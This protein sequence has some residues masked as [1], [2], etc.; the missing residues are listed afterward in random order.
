[1]GTG[2][3]KDLEVARN[4]LK[5]AEKLATEI[6][7]ANS[8]GG[9]LSSVWKS[10]WDGDAA[11][12][13]ITPEQRRRMWDYFASL[14]CQAEINLNL[15]SLCFKERQWMS[16]GLTARRSWKL[17]EEADQTWKKIKKYGEHVLPE[18]DRLEEVDILSRLE[19][20]IGLYHFFVSLVPPGL[21]VIVEAIGFQANRQLGISEL[22]SA[23]SRKG[24]H[25]VTA[26]LLLV[27][28]HNFF[29]QEDDPAN[30]LISALVDE[31]YHTSPAIRLMGGTVAR[32][33]G[34]IAR[35]IESYQLVTI[36]FS[37][38]ENFFPVFFFFFNSK[39]FFLLLSLSEISDINI[40][41]DPRCEKPTPGRFDP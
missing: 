11:P 6:Q 27:A 31:G 26:S 32:R 36:F 7:E 4:A 40:I 16:I 29:M 9:T 19:F 17:F 30:S 34:N 28:Y 8:E 25:Y 37:I 14:V 21:L 15:L 39:F 10:L 13:E 35:A 2:T 33:Q 5:D 18:A 1:M 23:V 41:G 20:G 12:A 3:D 24:I 22:K 38:F